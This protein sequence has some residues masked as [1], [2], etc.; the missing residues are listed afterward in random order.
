MFDIKDAKREDKTF[1]RPDKK[2]GKVQE[3]DLKYRK[4]TKNKKDYSF[5]LLSS[6][7]FIELKLDKEEFG[8]VEYT[9]RKDKNNLNSPVI[10]VALQVV[11]RN[12]AKIFKKSSKVGNKNPMFNNSVMEKHLIEA[13]ILEDKYGNQ[14]IKMVKQVYDS[15]IFELIKDKK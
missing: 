8:L 10:K 13:G 9:I 5:F 15:S 2:G 7:L 3:F 12:R 11:K 1:T 6:K 14:F 4:T